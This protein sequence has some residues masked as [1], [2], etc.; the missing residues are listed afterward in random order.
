VLIKSSN[1][2]FVGLNEDG[3]MVT[4]NTDNDWRKMLSFTEILNHLDPIDHDKAFRIVSNEL[5]R[6]PNTAIGWNEN[7]RKSY[8]ESQ[9][10]YTFRWNLY[11]NAKR[12]RDHMLKCHGIKLTEYFGKHSK[13]KKDQRKQKQKAK[14]ALKAGISKFQVN[15]FHTV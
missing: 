12:V 5:E 4:Y 3:D 6:N 10:P 9:T 8:D 15:M 14:K 13:E 11:A 2:P 1:T 7:S